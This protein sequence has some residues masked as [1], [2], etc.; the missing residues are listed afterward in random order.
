MQSETKD[1][2]L[3]FILYNKIPQFENILFW[4][5]MKVTVLN[6]TGIPYEKPDPF[7]SPLSYVRDKTWLLC[8]NSSP[9]TT[10]YN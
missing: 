6:F 4:I 1:N 3:H 5:I 9:N 2:K 10:Q 8:S 7:P